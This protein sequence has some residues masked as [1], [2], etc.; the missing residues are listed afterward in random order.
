MQKHLKLMNSKEWNLIGKKKKKMF[1]FPGIMAFYK[2]SA[3]TLFILQFSHFFL[4]FWK[5]GITQFF[6]SK[7][8]FWVL[9]HG[10]FKFFNEKK[11]L[12]PEKLKIFFFCLLVIMNDKFLYNK[13]LLDFLFTIMDIRYLW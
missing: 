6:N 13:T 4:P 12:L 7:K 9:L 3:A 11:N 8:K 2:M 10:H 1:S 5:R